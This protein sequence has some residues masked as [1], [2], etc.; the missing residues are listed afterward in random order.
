ML[1][2]EVTEVMFAVEPDLYIASPIAGAIGMS[3]FQTPTCEA[4]INKEG[5]VVGAVVES[6]LLPS[7]QRSLY[8]IVLNPPPPK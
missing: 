7:V 3:V 6:A 1:P 2:L 4:V 8:T 5:L